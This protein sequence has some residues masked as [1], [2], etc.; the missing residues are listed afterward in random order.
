MREGPPP[1]VV[2]MHIIGIAAAMFLLLGLFTPVA[3]T[4]AAFATV[5]ITIARFSGQSPGDPWMALSQAFLATTLVMIGPGAWSI[6]ARLFGRKH[7]R[8]SDR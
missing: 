1:W 4:F 3:G 2:A 5:W 6:D 8:L 7:I